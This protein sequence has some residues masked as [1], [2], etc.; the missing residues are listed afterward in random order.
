MSS[1]RR[2]LLTATAAA[3][4]LGALWFVPSANATSDSPVRDAVA[5]SPSPQVAEQARVAATTAGD[6]VTGTGARLADTGSFDSTPYVLGGTLFLT[7]GAG[8]VAYSVRRE[9]LGF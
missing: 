9:R 8:F 5:A 1:A 6:S 3:S 4:L 2:P 7:L